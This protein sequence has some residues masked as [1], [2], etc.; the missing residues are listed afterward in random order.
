M[1]EKLEKY[2]KEMVAKAL[3]KAREATETDEATETPTM[4]DYHVCYRIAEK[5]TDK[6]TYDERY[7]NLIN[8]IRILN[9]PV[10]SQNFEDRSHVSTSVWTVK[11]SMSASGL[12]EELYEVLS[13]SYDVLEVTEVD[14]TNR[15]ISPKPT[16]A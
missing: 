1:S 16:K 11:T 15:K 13:Q 2:A 14:L 12:Y 7:E 8:R 5:K 9:T 6:G 4:R 3:K 10:Q